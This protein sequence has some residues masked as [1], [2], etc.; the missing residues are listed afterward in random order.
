MDRIW[1]PWRMAY[2]RG[3]DASRNA[4]HTEGG[5]EE[6]IF[7][8]KPRL[9]STHDES[10]LI[11]ARRE[12]C[13]VIMNLYPYNNS[14]L[15]VVP[16]RHL[17]DFTLLEAVELLDCQ[18]ALQDAVRVMQRTLQPQ[19]WNIGLNLGKA[20]GAGIDQHLHWHVVPR[21]VGDTNFFPVLGETKVISESI[22]DSWQR[23]RDGFAAL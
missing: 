4:G 10:N 12:S 14:H 13:F 8:W 22:Q 18:R 5:V 19:G 6:C 3:L 7:C 21:W 9:E 23:M 1:A 11:V 15:M 20:A 2:I 17:C 16:Y